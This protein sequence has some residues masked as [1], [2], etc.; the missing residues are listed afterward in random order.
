MPPLTP[1]DRVK[2][3]DS[4]FAYIDSTGKR[5]LPI[6][7]AAGDQARLRLLRAAK[8]HGGVPIGA[9]GAA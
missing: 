8:K 5:R 2:S 4:A 3:P 7:D 9:V 6:N 1:R